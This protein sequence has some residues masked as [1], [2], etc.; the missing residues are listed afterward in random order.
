MNTGLIATASVMLTG[1]KH[2]VERNRPV[3]DTEPD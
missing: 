2:V 3:I 1:L